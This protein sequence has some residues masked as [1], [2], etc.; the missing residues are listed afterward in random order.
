M[1]VNKI[2][3]GLDTFGEVAL[4]SHTNER[5]SF[6]ESLRHIVEEGK[7]AEKVGVDLFALGEHHREEYSIASPQMLLAALATVTEKMILGT[8]VTVLSSDD[9]IRLYQQFATLDAISNGRAQIMLGRGSFTESYGLFGYDLTDYNELFEEK[10]GLF[11]ELVQGGPVTWQGK[12][13]PTLNNVEVFPKMT[14]NKLD[15]HIGVG[16]TPES[17]VR[18]A[19]LGFP[20]MLAII[21]GQ[22]IRFKP[23]IELYEKA[24]EQLGQ[25]IH[26]VGI[27]SHG[28]IA[29][30]DEE[31]REMARK[32]YIPAFNQLGSERGWA[33]MTLEQLDYEIEHGS[34]YVGSPETVARKMAQVIKEMGIK[35][36][37]M[38]YGMG[39][40][41][42]EERFKTIEL[43]GTQ[44]I[45]RVKELLKEGN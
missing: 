7:L 15:V 1:D 22:P 21:G 32:Y 41:T 30:T 25:P 39:G 45:P 9:P 14:E 12:Y 44:V 18:A 3:F 6:E 40:Q 26:P 34:Y 29:Q 43:Y 27:H 31:A 35:R 24:A 8:G 33:P 17:V 16:G 37:D 36:F 2:I 13:T 19:R 10:I 5:I 42:Q 4:D 11:N 28:V 23:Y 38:I 20:L